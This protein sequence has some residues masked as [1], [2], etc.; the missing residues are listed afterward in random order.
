M[1]TVTATTAAATEKIEGATT[2]QMQ[3]K[4]EDDALESKKSISRLMFLS[5]EVASYFIG[6]PVFMLF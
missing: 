4:V 6:E 1:T 3:V 2:V 5:P